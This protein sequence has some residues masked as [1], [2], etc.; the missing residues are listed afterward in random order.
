MMF[1]PFKFIFTVCITIPYNGYLL[2][3][4]IFAIQSQ[5]VAKYTLD[6]QFLRSHYS[7]PYLYCNL[8]FCGFFLFAKNG[9][10]ENTR[11]TV[12]LYGFINY[13]VFM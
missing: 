3:V 8:N 1:T 9:L 11:Y 13:K 6:F 10:A 12:F 7:Y 5:K 4:E 2:W